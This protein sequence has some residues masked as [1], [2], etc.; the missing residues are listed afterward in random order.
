[1]H[2]SLGSFERIT[3][4]TLGEFTMLTQE[5]LTK[6][7]KDLIDAQM[8]QLARSE[9]QTTHLYESFKQHPYFSLP[10]KKYVFQSASS[11]KT[12]D[13]MARSLAEA[14]DKA[15]KSFGVWIHIG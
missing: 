4:L 6:L 2:L 13:I 14:T 15:S 10:E 5:Q 11:G 1:M 12:K 8:N 3:Q 9:E 7:D